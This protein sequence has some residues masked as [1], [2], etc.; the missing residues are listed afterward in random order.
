[1]DLADLIIPE[2][3]SP[4]ETGMCMLHRRLLDSLVYPLPFDNDEVERRLLAVIFAMREPTWPNG[5][6]QHISYYGFRFSAEWLHRF[7]WKYHDGLPRHKIRASRIAAFIKS[8]ERLLG[9]AEPERLAMIE[10]LRLSRDRLFD[11]VVNSKNKPFL[12][13]DLIDDAIALDAMVCDYP[14]NLNGRYW[15]TATTAAG[16]LFGN[17]AQAGVSWARML[18]A[19]KR[20]EAKG[21]GMP[22]AIQTHPRFSLL[23]KGCFWPKPALPE[24]VTP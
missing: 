1:M 19:N 8:W 4:D 16:S 5:G 2:G 13:D 24:E 9:E 3:R 10:H 23:L 6:R 7:N 12:L 17:L 22:K 11:M 21:N 14:F 15:P 20:R 18:E